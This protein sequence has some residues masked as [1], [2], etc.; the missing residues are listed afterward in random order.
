M[1]GGKAE[2]SAPERIVI[3]DIRTCFAETAGCDIIGKESREPQRVVPEVDHHLEAT[4]AAGCLQIGQYV[5]EIPVSL[6]VV[7]IDAPRPVPL[8]ELQQERRQI[9]RQVSIVEARGP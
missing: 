5:H 3:A 6:V 9:V 1:I 2:A 4:G 8:P 7:P